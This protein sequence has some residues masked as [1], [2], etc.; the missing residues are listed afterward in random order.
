MELNVIRSG[1][2]QPVVFIHGWGMHAGVWRQAAQ[3]VSR[4][5]CAIRVDL[6]GFGESPYQPGCQ[7][8]E[9]ADRLLRH[10]GEDAVWVGWS[11]GGLLAMTLAVERPRSLKKCLCV[12]AS[13]C[14]AR[15][16]DW[17]HG[18]SRELLDEFSSQLAQDYPLTMKRFFS[19]QARGTDDSLRLTREM[20][21]LFSAVKAPDPRA[22]AD[23]LQW[24][25]QTDLR[26]RLVRLER[27]LLLLLGEHDRIVD[28]ACLRELPPNRHIS[29]CVIPGAAHAPFLSHPAQFHILLK[30]FIHNDE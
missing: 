17:R 10:V 30:E 25:Q 7:L 27:P 18:M 16:D 13:P 19:L 1:R 8:L 29:S 5:A 9:V 28:P 22:L 11:L 20:R 12:A 4:Y 24:L 6:P 21:R 3:E 2:G 15:R 14:F 26:T 23:G